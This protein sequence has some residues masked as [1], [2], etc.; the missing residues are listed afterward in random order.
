[1][2][3]L[4]LVCILTSLTVWCTLSGAGHALANDPPVITCPAPIDPGHLCGIIHVIDGDDGIFNLGDLVAGSAVVSDPNGDPLTLTVISITREGQPD[5]P[6]N[7]P[8]IENNGDFS[9]QTT[10]SDA[11]GAWE[12]CLEVSDGELA[13]TCCFAVNLSLKFYLSIRDVTGTVDTISSLDGQDRDI[14]VNLSPAVPLSALNV[15]LRFNDATVYFRGPATPINNLADWEYF[16]YR[17]SFDTSCAGGEPQGLISIS[18]TA[19]L[20]NGSLVTP[21]ES[22]YGLD[23][24]IVHL[25]FTVTRDWIYLGQC[26]PFDF[27]SVDCDDNRLVSKDGSIEY[28]PVGAAP[29]CLTSST[30]ANVETCR[31]AICVRSLEPILD[32]NLNGIAPEIGDVILMMN[33]FLH[34][35]VVLDPIWMAVQK[36]AMDCNND[37]IPGTFADLACMIRIITGET[38]VYP[39]NGASSVDVMAQRED[40]HLTLSA[41]SAAALSGGLFTFRYDGVDVGEPRLAQPI[42]GMTVKSYA[43]NGELRVLLMPSLTEKAGVIAPGHH[44]L[45]DIP[46]DGDGVL[47]LRTIDLADASGTTLPGRILDAGANPA[48]YALLQ[49]Y[50][51]PFNA[52]TVIPFDLRDASEWELTIY[53]ILGQAVR[54]FN[55]LSGASRVEVQWDGTDRN[56]QSVASGM[57]FY[58]MRAGNFVAT[59]KMSLLK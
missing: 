41:A 43:A 15:Q 40:R 49:N 10:V 16:T 55:G 48:S 51:N 13:D 57:Y 8:V 20:D 44:V 38:D 36:Q 2:K 22:S 45:I 58:R 50:P 24:N 7:A 29:E 23:G 14:Y 1:M 46:V 12:F 6:V 39:L 59:R 30:V 31:G 33:Y 34:G 11:E 3:L 37:G 28:L 18:A 42:P 35:D 56:G 19:D 27:C 32:V 9:W 52:G 25:P 53:N 17:V 5:V 21:P 54:T 26:L 4:R 47:T